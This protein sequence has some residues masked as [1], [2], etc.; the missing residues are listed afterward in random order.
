MRTLVVGLVVGLM[1]LPLSGTQTAA[2]SSVPTATASPTPV[3]PADDIAFTRWDGHDTELWTI[4]PAT[5]DERRLTNNGE[6]ELEP[7]WSPDHSRIAF[8]RF[9]SGGTKA[10]LVIDADGGNKVR[11]TPPRFFSSSPTWSPDGQ[12]IAFAANVGGT[13][14]V[15]LWRMRAD[16]SERTQLTDSPDVQEFDPSWQPTGTLLAYQRGNRYNHAIFTL[17]ANDGSQRMRVTANS[18]AA[19]SPTWEPAGDAV[20]YSGW[21]NG[22]K[23]RDLYMADVF[24]FGA[25]E[26][27]RLFATAAQDIRPSSHGA[28]AW[29]TWQCAP[30][31]SGFEICIMRRSGTRTIL[32]TNPTDDEDPAW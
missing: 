28:T 22:A 21:P 24:A 9:V 17:L 18:A 31:G 30:P 26:P 3:P 15:N 8:A 12:W 20:I 14:E 6:D 1:A 32:T 19:E 13:G 4:D 2:G 11:L 7:S 16:G 29:L 27:T 23:S 25:Q 5:R 10:I